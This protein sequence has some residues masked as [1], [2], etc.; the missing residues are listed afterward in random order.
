MFESAELRLLL[1]ALDGEEV[2]IGTDEET[3]KPLKVELHRKPQLRAMV[4]L[5]ANT[6]FGNTD[7]S[8]LPVKAVDLEKGWVDFPRVKNATPRRVP[9]W[10]ETVAAIREWMPMRPKAKDPKDSGLL[11]LTCRGARWVRVGK[12][13]ASCD[14]LGMEFSKVLRNLKLKRHGL[15]FYAMRHGFETVAGETTDQVA[16]DAIMGHSPKGMA[17]VYRERISDD[18]L[19]AVTEHVREWLFA[20]EPDEDPDDP[21]R[22]YFR[23]FATRATL[24]TPVGRVAKL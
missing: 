21:S 10:P 4:L 16:V 14:M 6:G 7:L 15:S 3:G 24:A 20:D 17:G 8:S 13:G 19:V 11:F 22:K 9:L 12:S 5:A 18:R 2:G 23:E 1:S